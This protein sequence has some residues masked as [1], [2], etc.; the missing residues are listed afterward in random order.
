MYASTCQKFSLSQTPTA[1]TS[2]VIDNENN[3][4]FVGVTAHMWDIGFAV[5]VSD[6]PVVMDYLVNDPYIFIKYI[7]Y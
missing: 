6:S 3:V 2:K 7:F 1:N 4:H 5:W